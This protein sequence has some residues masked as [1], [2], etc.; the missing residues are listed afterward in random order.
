MGGDGAEAF[1]I[2]IHPDGKEPF[3]PGSLERDL[4]VLISAAARNPG[5]RLTLEQSIPEAKP[6]GIKLPNM[7][8]KQLRKEHAMVKKCCAVVPVVLSL[9]ILL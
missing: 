2:G 5:Q 4:F 9:K 8:E 3:L 6:F 1:Q 7:E